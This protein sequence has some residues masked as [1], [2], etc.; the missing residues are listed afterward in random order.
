MKY[1]PAKTKAQKK[2]FPKKHPPAARGDDFAPAYNKVRP[3]SATT[4]A[5]AILASNY[6]RQYGDA[7]YVPSNGLG[8][9][10]S[11]TGERPV[12]KPKPKPPAIKQYGDKGYKPSTGKG[13][14]Y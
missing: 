1:Q 2:D 6:I 13:V 4:P 9:G 12:V 14:G 7:G 11:K 8:V 5:K 3:Q 10:G